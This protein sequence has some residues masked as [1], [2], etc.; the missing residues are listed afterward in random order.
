MRLRGPPILAGRSGL[1]TDPIV[2][3]RERAVELA[4]VRRAGL[5]QVRPAA[6]APACRLRDLLDEPAGGEALDEVPGDGG[7]QIYLAVAHAAHA[8]DTRAEPLP[9]RVRHP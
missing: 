1:G 3:E 9:Q 2:D 8:D 7:H 4:R 6:A 5:R